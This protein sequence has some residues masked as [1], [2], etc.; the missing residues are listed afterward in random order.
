MRKVLDTETEQACDH[1]FNDAVPLAVVP[2]ALG[3]VG[4][5]VCKVTARA[6]LIPSCIRPVEFCIPIDTNALTA[7]GA[8]L[9]LNHAAIVIGNAV[10]GVAI[11]VSDLAE[12]TENA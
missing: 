10:T 7:A 5:I 2:P 11:V 12:D 3:V 1:A 8:A 6:A 9:T 4:V